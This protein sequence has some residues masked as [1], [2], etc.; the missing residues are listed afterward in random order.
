M[1][2]AGVC[3][4]REAEEVQRREQPQQR[5]AAAVARR[6]GLR[7]RRARRHSGRRRGCGGRRAVLRPPAAAAPAC[8][9]A[10]GRA[11]RGLGV[12]ARTGGSASSALLV[13]QHEPARKQ[14][15]DAQPQSTHRTSGAPPPTGRCAARLQAAVRMH[16]ACAARVRA[17][18]SEAVLLC[19]CAECWRDAARAHR[20]RRSC[21]TTCFPLASTRGIA[22]IALRCSADRGGNL[23]GRQVSFTQNIYAGVHA[24]AA[25]AARGGGA[26]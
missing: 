3:E 26:R 6:D 19:I 9:F 20:S 24:R 17:A 18:R 10:G 15:G 14:P 8:L 1:C 13:A 4:G 7:A 25:G 2:K 22:A 23:G 21:S 11:A 16:A 5:A 12:R